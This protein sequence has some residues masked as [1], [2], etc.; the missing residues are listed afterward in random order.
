MSVARTKARCCRAVYTNVCAQTVYPRNGSDH[1]RG[2]LA[3]LALAAPC[4]RARGVRI[5][6]PLWQQRA[7][8]TGPRSQP[9]GRSAGYSRMP[10][11]RGRGAP[12]RTNSRESLSRFRGR[13]ITTTRMDRKRRWCPGP[14]RFV[15]FLI[16]ASR[17]NR[18]RRGARF[19]Q[20]STAARST[21]C[22]IHA[23]GWPADTELR[24]AERKG[25]PRLTSNPAGAVHS[26]WCGDCI[27]A[28][29]AQLVDRTPG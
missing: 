24:L 9:R 23:A 26:S 3:G 14:A 12:D 20:R 27:F 28:F 8:M 18:A 13:R 21:A 16:S 10:R 5:A 4:R 25:A 2:T 11:A 1:S 15:R 17:S 29:V 6:R 7:V 19:A 22:A